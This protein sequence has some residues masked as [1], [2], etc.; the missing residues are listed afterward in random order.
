MKKKHCYTFDKS[1]FICAFLKG[2]DKLLLHLA[3]VNRLLFINFFKALF[4]S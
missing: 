3:W 1:L 2:K 4:C